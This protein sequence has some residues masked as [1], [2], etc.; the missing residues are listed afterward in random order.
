MKNA[1]RKVQKKQV[2]EFV[3]LLEEAHQ[4]I[5][6]AMRKKNIDL[7]KKLLEQCWNGANKASI[8][9][10]ALEGEEFVT[11]SLL[12]AYSEIV[13]QVYIALEQVSMLKGKDVEQILRNSWN[14]VYDSVKKDISVRR[15]VVFCPYKASMWDSLESVWIE[16]NKD[17]NCDVYV[18]PIPYFDKLPDGSFGQMHYE[19]KQYPKYVLITDYKAYD[20]VKNQPDIIFIHNP[21]D[22]FNH[23]TSIHPYFYT[24]N[25]KKFTDKLVYIPYFI[26]AEPKEDVMITMTEEGKQKMLAFCVQPGVIESTVVIVQSEIMKNLYVNLLS[27]YFGENTRRKWEKK[28]LGLGSPKVDKIF[29]IKGEYLDIPEKWRTVLY[30]EDGRRKKV[31]LYNTS[32][33]SFLQYNECM[34]NKMRNVFKYFY[35]NREEVVLLWRPHPLIKATIESMR[36]NLWNAYE[37]LVQEYQKAEWGIYDDTADL[38]RAIELADAYY[39]DR[40]SLVHLC[41]KKGMSITIQDMEKVEADDVINIGWLNSLLFPT[42]GLTLYR[43]NRLY[44][45]ATNCEVLMCINL[46][47]G[48]VESISEMPKEKLWGL[49]VIYDNY[50]I[51]SPHT[52]KNIYVFDIERNKFIKVNDNSIEMKPMLTAKIFQ[53]GASIY[54]FPKEGENVFCLNMKELTIKKSS[55]MYDSYLREVGVKP[56]ILVATDGYEYKNKLYIAAGEV[57]YIIEFSF[58][59][60]QCKFYKIADAQMGFMQLRGYDGNLY[61]LSHNKKIFQWCIEE[62]KI[63]ESWEV[64]LE[65]DQKIERL[66]DSICIENNI[67]FLATGTGLIPDRKDFGIRINAK[68]NNIDV[69][70]YEKEFKIKPEEGESFAFSSMDEEGNIYFISS[71]HNLHIYNIYTQAVEKIRLYYHDS[72]RIK[73]FTKNSMYG[74]NCWNYFMQDNE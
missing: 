29:S 4:E 22:E 24:K 67:Y 63:K 72:Q 7:A 27:E 43:N 47:N 42:A 59:S 53:R 60:E 64:Y 73:H 69:I 12:Q 3:L 32:V 54:F 51:F 50:L 26:L 11:V 62:K 2:E 58:E 37:K 70:T 20:F 44:F 57:G 17:E 52:S 55:Y 9:I 71:Y 21:Y 18:V 13:N 39:G 34:L 45:R 31:I 56:S 23:V 5:K 14:E 48:Q 19:G 28:I 74:K 16:A 46:S 65:A 36:P 68:T 35:K 41:Q 61:L 25:L 66:S 15:E 33:S 38:N 10:A 6:N 1:M 8:M 30:K 49:G 40:S